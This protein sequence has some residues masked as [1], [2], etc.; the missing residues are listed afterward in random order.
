MAQPKAMLNSNGCAVI[1]GALLAPANA[2]KRV[3]LLFNSGANTRHTAGA[4]P[5]V[6]F[7][8]PV[9]CEKGTASAAGFDPLV[10]KSLQP[11]AAQNS[12]PKCAP[13]QRVR[14]W[15][16]IDAARHQKMKL[17]AANQKQSGQEFLRR[18]ISKS[19]VEYASIPGSAP[20]LRSEAAARQPSRQERRKVAVWVNSEQRERIRAAASLRGQTIQDL[21]MAALDPQ[22]DRIEASTGAHRPLFES[23]VDELDA[24]NAVVSGAIVPLPN[25]VN[26]TRSNYGF[27]LGALEAA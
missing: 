22:L 16:R 23:I 10:R 18:S 8:A 4:D 9:L 2:R 7:V 25:C 1:T 3:E 26:A 6:E 20:A 19:L 17:A 13:V 15:L 12:G 14:V 24:S 27:V 11:A 5:L 21:L